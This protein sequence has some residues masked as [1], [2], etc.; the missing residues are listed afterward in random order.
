MT[1]IRKNVILAA[2]IF[3]VCLFCCAG[4]GFGSYRWNEKHFYDRPFPPEYGWP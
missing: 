3:A 2:G 1:D 4:A